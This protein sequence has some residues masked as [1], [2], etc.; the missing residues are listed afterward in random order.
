MSNS[1]HDF[2]EGKQGGAS[3][4]NQRFL[5]LDDLAH[6]PEPS[7]MIEGLFERN[8][9][10]MLAGPSYSF[11]S[12]LALDWLLNMAA[13]RNWIGRVTQPAKVAYI[14]GEGK[15][16]LLKR[17]RAWVIYNNLSTLENA[18]LKQNFKVTFNVTQL[19]SSDS[20]DQLLDDLNA[21]NFSP[22]VIAVDTFARA[23]VGLDENDAR[24]I[25]EWVDQADRLRQLGFTVLFLHHTKKN[26][27]M[28]V[29]YRGST[30]LMGAMDTAMT[31]VR[32]E[33]YCTLT[34]TKQKDHDEGAPLKF[35]RHMVSLGG[36]KESCV[37]L[38]VE[39]PTKREKVEVPVTLGAEWVEEKSAGETDI[40]N[41]LVANSTFESDKAR[42]AVLAEKLGIS[43][44]AARTRISR[45]RTQPSSAAVTSQLHVTDVIDDVIAA[46]PLESER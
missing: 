25:G 8:S 13:G 45:A 22:D 17:I 19:A 12:F 30:A 29:Q 9:L 23:A 10:I 26:T 15:A 11:K 37:L 18:R 36:D 3:P 34:V 4:A 1:A 35:K 5:S 42:A 44:G 14:L 31:L 7:W 20:V 41:A 38:P 2:V 28:G 39:M 24:D 16:S 21:E 27:E 46:T 33:N 6:M 32:T 43:E 40:I